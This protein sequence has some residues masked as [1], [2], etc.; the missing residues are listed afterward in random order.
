MAV[1][2]LALGLG[3]A[4]LLFGPAALAGGGLR[5]GAGDAGLASGVL[6]AVT[7][8]AA[9]HLQG[10]RGAQTALAVVA[11][12]VTLVTGGAT[13]LRSA[14]ERLVDGRR[15]G[16]GGDTRRPDRG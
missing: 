14:A 5:L 7:L 4:G 1:G 16:A 13:A 15:G 12:L 3:G 6:F 9:R 8:T 11:A 10:E 2:G